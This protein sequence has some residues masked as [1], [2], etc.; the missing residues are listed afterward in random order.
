MSMNHSPYAVRKENVHF[1]RFDNLSH[2]TFAERGM[3]EY[4]TFTIRS[5]RIIWSTRFSGSV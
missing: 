3:H 4:L 1:L 5:C 2:L